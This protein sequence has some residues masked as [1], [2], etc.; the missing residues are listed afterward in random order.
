MGFAYY[1]VYAQY[2]EV[3]RVE[4]LRSLNLSY[5]EIEDMGYALPVV[6]FNINYKKPAYYDDLLTI[7]T[8]INIMP[9]FKFI[10]NYIILNENGD[11]LNNGQVT[12]V[13]INK[14]T[15]KPCNAPDLI[16]E[17]LLEKF[18]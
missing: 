4:L 14:K 7:R 5:K 17:K 8:T 18:K 2:Y 3:G 11:E 10:F 1:G 12:L 15:V 13:F 9:S 6:N 16:I